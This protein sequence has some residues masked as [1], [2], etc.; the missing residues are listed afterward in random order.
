[1][2]IFLQIILTPNDHQM[3]YSEFHKIISLNHNKSFPYRKFTKNYHN[4]K[5]WLTASLKESIR[6]KNK[7]YQNRNKGSNHDERLA[8]YKRYRNKLNHILRAAQRKHFKDQILEDKTNLKKSWQIINMV[9]NKR[10]YK[11][12]C[13]E[14]KYNG[15]PSKMDWRLVTDL[16]FFFV[17]VGSTL[18]I[19]QGMKWFSPIIVKCLYYQCFQS[20]WRDWCII[21]LY[22]LSMLIIYYMNISLDSRKENLLIWL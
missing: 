5:P 7:L 8:H 10:K 20:Y 6:L 2:I 4:N 16:T 21:G 19:N 12:P 22:N 14:F 13:A 11:R 9:M 17:N 3:A 15:K 18:S 1:M